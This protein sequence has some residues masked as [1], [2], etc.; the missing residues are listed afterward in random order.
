M[1][2]AARRGVEETE[3][4]IVTV[5]FKLRYRRPAPTGTLVRVRGE[6]IRR[7]GRDFYMEGAIES[8]DGDVLVLAEARWRQIDRR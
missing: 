6:P 5:D 1:G 2:V 8:G 4:D 7:D 3:L